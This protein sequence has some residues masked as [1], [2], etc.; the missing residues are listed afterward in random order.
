MALHKLWRIV[1]SF[2]MLSWAVFWRTTLQLFESLL[3]HYLPLQCLLHAHLR[4]LL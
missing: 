4:M 3:S 2:P 1:L